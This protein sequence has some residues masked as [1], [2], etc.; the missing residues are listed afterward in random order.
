[1]T[2]G[3]AIEV[4]LEEID[5]VPE[6]ATNFDLWVP[7]QLTIRGEAIS[8]DVAMAVVLDRMLAKDFL[9]A[10]YTQGINGRTYHYSR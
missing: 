3:H 6:G 10:G 7:I 1:M 4:L 5:S 8:A 2:I 9:P